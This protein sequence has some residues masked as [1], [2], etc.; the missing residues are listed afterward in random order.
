MGLCAIETGGYESPG[1]GGFDYLSLETLGPQAAPLEWAANLRLESGKRAGGPAEEK[2]AGAPS[3]ACGAAT[4]MVSGAGP[5]L[6]ERGRR[7]DKIW[8]DGDQY[9]IYDQSYSS[10]A[11]AAAADEL[12]GHEKFQLSVAGWRARLPQ[13]PE[14][15]ARRQ[16]D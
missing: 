8:P 16:W 13:M 5:R 9:D 4:F 12:A 11:R 7:F 3:C 10:A 2:T 6:V 14:R 15:P 1:S